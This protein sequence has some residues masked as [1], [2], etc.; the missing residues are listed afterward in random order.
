MEKVLIDKDKELMPGDL[1]EMHF[2]T[3][4]L[5]VITATQI[6]LIEWRLEKR[7]DFDIINWSN[8]PGTHKII[9]TIRICEPP[10]DEPQVYKA[11]AAVTAAII[12]A[13]IVSAGVV[14]W[15]T[16]DK[17]YQLYEKVVESPAGK[18][19]VG[20]FGALSIAV[21]ALVVLSLWPKK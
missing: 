15:L 17:T 6:A 16:L 7:K 1:I 8:P 4:G 18:V 5:G 3:L 13:V 11:N 12:G 21:A 9:F 19:A 14:A 2:T 10:K 20:G